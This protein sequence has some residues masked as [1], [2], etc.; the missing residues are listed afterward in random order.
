MEQNQNNSGNRQPMQIDLREYAI[1]IWK[2]RR[3]I[4]AVTVAG[5]IIGIVAAVS[6]PREYTST[7]TFAPEGGTGTGG[8]SSALAALSGV[9]LGAGS[10]ETL[11]PALSSEIVSSK[12]FMCELLQ[13]PVNDSAGKFQGRLQD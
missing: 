9:T 5:F 1:R 13:T 4:L 10:Q 12:P 11:S 7:V 6:I 8:S 3:M 2:R